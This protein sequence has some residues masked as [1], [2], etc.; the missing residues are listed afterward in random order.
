MHQVRPSI[1]HRLN[2]AVPRRFLLAISGSLWTFAGALLCIRAAI[3]LN[4]FS[5]T[6]EII[7]Q[8]VCIGIAV[9]AYSFMFFK[10]VEKNIN[11]IGQLPERACLFAFTSWH[12]YFMIAFMVTIGITLRNSSLPK[13]YLS[14]PYDAMGIILLIGS[15]R[16]FRRFVSAATQHGV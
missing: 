7:L 10:V 11:R 16:F 8:L 14:I 4:E 3:W 13:V 9:A 1:V 5:I 2:P 15:V 6:A 12:G